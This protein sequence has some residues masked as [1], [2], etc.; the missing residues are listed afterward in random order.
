MYILYR[1]YNCCLYC[2]K[3]AEKENELY[4]DDDYDDAEKFLQSHFPPFGNFSLVLTVDQ[5]RERESATETDS[6]KEKVI[7]FI[8]FQFF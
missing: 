5:L 3:N 1:V 8:F 6:G 2:G 7:P 4:V